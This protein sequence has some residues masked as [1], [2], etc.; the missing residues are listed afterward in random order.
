MTLCKTK[1][2]SLFSRIENN[3]LQYYTIRV[4]VGLYYASLL[5]ID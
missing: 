5:R 2:N 3:A 1:N 4:I